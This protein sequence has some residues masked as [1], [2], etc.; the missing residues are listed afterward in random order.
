MLGANIGTTITAFLASL[1][2]DFNGLV[3][4]L[5]HVIFNLIGTASILLIPRARQLPIFLAEGLSTRAVERK[6]WVAAYVII[7][8]ILLPLFGILIF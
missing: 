5:V 8:F 3:I 7:M 2:T 6:S 4:A 1:A